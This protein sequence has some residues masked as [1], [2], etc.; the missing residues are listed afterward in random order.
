MIRD[1]ANWLIYFK[2]GSGREAPRIG[3]ILT[4]INI[5]VLFVPES[6]WAMVGIDVSSQ[7]N[8]LSEFMQ[9]Y[10]INMEHKNAA[11]VFWLM[12]PFTSL[13]NS[14]TVAAVIN[15]TAYEEYLRKRK[16]IMEN[17]LTLF[18]KNRNT[19]RSW[20]SDLVMPGL[21]IIIAYVWGIL[22][23]HVPL[24]LLG[25]FIPEQNRIALIII[26]GGVPLFVFPL[27]LTFFIA[28]ARAVLS[29]SKQKDGI[30]E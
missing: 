12:L 26:G 3:V 27:I 16:F 15:I 20:R 1:V 8:E 2:F 5:G 28:E 7:W 25:E 4:A 21:V 17:R 23:W 18:E 22:L 13:I 19:P 6:M 11:Y 9:Y 14:V 30:V 24:S 29:A 10:L